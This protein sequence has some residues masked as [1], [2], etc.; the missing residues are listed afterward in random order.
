M[1]MSK[2]TQDIVCSIKP[3]IPHK[4]SETTLKIHKN[5]R[6]ISPLPQQAMLE[7]CC[8]Q[9]LAYKYNIAC[10]GEGRGGLG[11]DFSAFFSIFNVVSIYFVRDCLRKIETYKFLIFFFFILVKVCWLKLFYV[12]CIWWL[13]AMLL[14]II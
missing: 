10:W 13:M 4:N 8:W 11:E 2:K 6:K 9:R 7:G 12:S 1:N 3:T 5:V 14:F